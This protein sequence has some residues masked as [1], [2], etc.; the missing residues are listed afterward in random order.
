MARRWYGVDAANLD[1]TNNPEGSRATINRRVEEKTEDRIRDLL[2]PG[3]IDPMTRLVI[4]NAVYFKGTWMKQFDPEATREEEF[5][6]GPGETVPVPMMHRMDAGAVYGYNETDTLQVLEMPYAC[7]SGSELVMLILLPRE[8]NLTVAEEALGSIGDLRRSLVKQRVKVSIPKFRF[9]ADYSLPEVLSAMG[10]PTAFT[11]D[12][13]FSGMDGTDDLF[14]SDAVHKAFV[15]VNEEGTEA[16]AATGVVVGNTGACPGTTPVF[17]A[18]HPFIFLIIDKDSGTILFMGRVADPVESR[19][20]GTR[21]RRHAL[22]AQHL[23]LF[24]ALGADSPPPQ[25]R[26]RSMIVFCR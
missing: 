10:M 24:C 21:E 12:A 8:D 19:G 17:R 15:D 7:E 3:S 14:I 1:F 9:E 2:P 6:I 5:R 4:T 11:A 16:A 22:Q 20:A 13:D 18:D 23:T 25:S 26:T